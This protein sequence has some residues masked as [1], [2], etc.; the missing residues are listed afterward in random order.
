MSEDLPLGKRIPSGVG[1][2]PSWRSFSSSVLST[3]NRR[4]AAASN[5]RIVL[6]D[7]PVK[8]DAASRILPLGIRLQ[9][10]P[11]ARLFIV[12]YGDSVYAGHYREASLALHVRT[13]MGTGGSVSWM[14]VDDDTALIMGRELLACPKKLAAIDYL[15]DEA[16]IRAGVRR[17][18]VDLISV[19]AG[20][21][22][23]ERFPDHVLGMRCFN[24]GGPGQ[25][26]L[27]NPVWA[28]RLDETIHDSFTASG[29]LVVNH[30]DYDPIAEVLEDVENPVSL[31]VARIDISTVRYM[32]PVWFA[33]PSWFLETYDLR[34]R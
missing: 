30:S 32:F 6:A 19:D 27:V 31:R 7:L 9:E 13:P 8:R 26:F 18:G 25:A 11:R 23:E 12:D 2:R 15:Q 14:V 29:N 3:L 22:T 1:R 16:T 24:V 28:L 10:P 21:L 17:R 20:D 5:A 34:F 4:T 33:G